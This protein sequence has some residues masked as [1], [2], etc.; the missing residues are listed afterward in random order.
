[1]ELKRYQ[2]SVIDDLNAFLSELNKTEQPARAYEAHWNEKGFSVGYG[3]VQSYKDN[4]PGVPNVC[5]KVPT[6]GGKTFIATSAL[7]P[8]FDFQPY[9]KS[10]AVVWLVPSD[11]ILEQTYKA[12][13][14]AEHPYRQRLDADF[15]HRVEVYS[16]Q[17]LLNGQNFN[18][19]SVVEQLSIFVL[20]YD[21]FR[22]RTKEGRKAYHENGN[23]ALFAKFF[24]DQSILL[25][26][27]D[28]TALIQV[29]RYLNPITIVDESHHATTPLSKEMLINFNPSFVLDLTATPK[30]DSNIIS[31]VDAL[32][33][34]AENMVKL[35]VIVYNRRTHNDVVTDA[36]QIRDKLELQAAA[37]QKESG[38]Y[39]RP[40]VLFQAQPRNTSDSTTFDKLKQTL[41]DIGISE[42]QVA[43]KTAEKNEL[44]GV[45]LLSENCAIR[46]II[47]INALKEGWDCPFAYILA[48]IA[49]RSSTVDVEQ[50]LGRILRLP[51]TQKNKNSV[52]N[53]SYVI[54]SSDDFHET[55]ERVV[56][57]LNNAGF[58]D[59]EYRIG[60]LIADSTEIDPSK[61]GKARASEIQ[62][63]EIFDDDEA[64]PIVDSE[65][66]ATS[67]S[68]QSVSADGTLEID[69]L[70]SAAAEQAETYEQT[71]DLYLKSEEPI[72]PTDLKNNI[73]YYYLNT[74]YKD[75][76][77]N[78]RL[79][80]FVID[81][82][83]SIFSE[84]ETALLTPERLA[85]GFRLSS[86][87]ADISFSALDAE[88]AKIDIEGTSGAIP[89]AW[90]LAGTDNEFFKNWFN[91]NP[92]EKRIRICADLIV[93]TLSRNNAIND[94]DLRDYVSRVI[95][96]LSPE[97]VDDL[98]QSPF[99][100]AQKIK[101][102]IESLLTEYSRSNFYILI[103]QGKIRC[104][105]CYVFP[106]TISPLK[107]VTTIP[108]SLYTAEEDMNGLEKDIVWELANL[109]N[110]KWWHRNIARTGFA[111]N[112]FINAYP[113]VIVQTHSGKI[114]MIEPKGDHLGN[115]DSLNKVTIGRIWQ[116]KAGD[117]Y[118]YYMVFRNRELEVV[119]AY[120]FD[121]FMEIVKGL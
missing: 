112:G 117:Q 30:D 35:P 17:Q 102:K 66:I 87:E 21:S 70:L 26:D 65:Q 6:G 62:Q 12:L 94:R 51:Y 72:V 24:D 39:I 9:T 58:S 106:K 71:A 59:K 31:Y 33:L 63:I 83:P 81:T 100:Y 13:S 19:S 110:I 82:P 11:A 111:I 104:E 91:S 60:S 80:Q 54:T 32:Q 28:E 108:N 74:A 55:L 76:A 25:A 48:T 47:T 46:Y 118:R 64:F 98:Q 22:T 120:H 38:R 2:R 43:I 96:T 101:A 3:G 16:K 78:L 14:D 97:Q 41:I 89:K 69:D 4:T 68:Q 92:V 116:N 10:K 53:I 86:K 93:S 88:I 50:I 73:T 37:E 7:K 119:G 15:A 8:I 45:D 95:D 61:D 20:S 29:I 67:I 113:D 114:L 90:K 42:E 105:P 52:L 103:E 75:E 99:P 115:E 34:K 40:I 1:M 57:G 49:N 109:P 107:T 79:P 27:T 84:K 85:E 44:A 18:P 36:I 23:L 121:R 56:V 5:I 77:E